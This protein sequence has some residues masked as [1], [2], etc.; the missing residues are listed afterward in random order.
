MHSSRM[1]QSKTGAKD[2]FENGVHFC[3]LDAHLSNNLHNVV[4]VKEHYRN[5]VTWLLLIWLPQVATRS[6]T[7]VGAIGGRSDLM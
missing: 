7:R 6:R 4:S 5:E 3:A 2:E 1:K